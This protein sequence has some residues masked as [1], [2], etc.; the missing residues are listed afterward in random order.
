[1][2]KKNSFQKKMFFYYSLLIIIVIVLIGLFSFVYVSRLL[3]EKENTNMQ[4][5]ISSI[6]A[7]LDSTV[8]ELDLVSV[9]VVFSKQVQDIMYDALHSDKKGE[10]YFDS[11]RSSKFRVQETLMSINSPKD[12][13]RRIS[14][15]NNG[16]NFL[17]IGT[18]VEDSSAVNEELKTAA[19]VDEVESLNGKPLIRQPHIDGWMKESDDV[20]SVARTLHATM[21]SISPDADGSQRSFQTGEPLGV[22]EVQQSYSRIEK[23]C[24]TEELSPLKI[25]VMDKK[26]EVIY[27]LDIDT[28]ELSY[29]ESLVL[30]SDNS[31]GNIFQNPTTD[32][33]ELVN[34]STSDYTNWTV[35]IAQPKADFMKPVYTFQRLIFIAGCLLVFIILLLTL[36][37]TNSLTLPI[38]ELRKSLSKVSID[39]FTVD[40]NDQGE[41]D[42]IILLN[43][44]FQDTLGRLNESVNQTLEARASESHAQLLAL[45]AQMNP[46]FLYNSLMAISSIGVEIDNREIVT[47]CSQLS[48]MLRYTASYKD[49]YVALKNELHHAGLYLKLTKWR[50]QEL[51]EF[52]FDIAPDMQDIIVPKYILQPIIENSINHGFGN[53]EPP[54]HISI[55]G[56]IEGNR[57]NITVIDNG[58]GFEQSLIDRLNE[59]L[60]LFRDGII[61][62][63]IPLELEMGGLGLLNIYIRLKLYYQDNAVFDIHNNKGGGAVV[64]LG[65]L[66]D[67]IEGVKEC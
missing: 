6:S 58:C 7:Q 45:Q 63:N 42:E 4:Q 17:S 21:S 26:G 65:G 47:M 60:N 3:K 39:N 31:T 37:I 15:F 61:A 64:A 59:K 28:N 46:H 53:T 33:T 43:R 32:V 36:A 66:T 34:Y 12:I 5:T 1:M 14:V 23:I 35:V 19:W 62:G 29:Y 8:K 54:W 56:Y 22:V 41:N 30:T 48:D 18:V 27:P 13:C 16:C 24:Q 10:N 9:Q 11:N 51:L 2:L 25:I 57:W 49:T 67:K 50:Y 55:K 44:A 38:R 40:I 52:D 20:I